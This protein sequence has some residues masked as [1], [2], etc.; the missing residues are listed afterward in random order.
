MGLMGIRIQVGH[1]RIFHNQV[2]HNHAHLVPAYHNHADLEQ[3]DHNLLDCV[4]VEPI[5]AGRTLSART[6]VDL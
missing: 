2:D 6:L 1:V 4:R 3:A 5:P